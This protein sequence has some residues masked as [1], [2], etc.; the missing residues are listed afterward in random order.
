MEAI[1]F[2]IETAFTN[3]QPSST[4]TQKIERVLAHSKALAQTFILE[5]G[6]SPETQTALNLLQQSTYAVRAAIMTSGAGATR[7][8]SGRAGQLT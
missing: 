3:A 6:D 7:G 8:L 5:C 1:H 2:N 4:Q